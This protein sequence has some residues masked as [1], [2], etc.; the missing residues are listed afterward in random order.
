MRLI[1]SF[2]LFT[3]SLAVWSAVFAALGYVFLTVAPCHWFGASF[4]GTCGYRGV[5]FTT[6]VCAALAICFSVATVISQRH[7]P[8]TQN[9]NNSDIPAAS[10]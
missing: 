2:L 3:L 10:T 1:K 8:P 7:K 4:E 6:V 9:G 5:F